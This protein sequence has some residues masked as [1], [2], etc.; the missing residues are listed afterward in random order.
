MLC[1]SENQPSPDDTPQSQFKSSSAQGKVGSQKT[2]SFSSHMQTREGS[3]LEL[4]FQRSEGI[5][6]IASLLPVN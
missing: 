6:S 2:E 1:D 3:C 5:L 4:S